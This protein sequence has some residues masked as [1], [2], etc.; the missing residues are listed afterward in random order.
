MS[1]LIILPDFSGADIAFKR[2]PLYTSRVQNTVSGREVAISYESYPRY[3]WQLKF[4]VLRD[5]VTTP[6]AKQLE[7]IFHLLAGRGDYFLFSDPQRGSVVTPVNIGTGTGAAAQFRA[8]FLHTEPVSG[9]T[10]LE[11]VQNIYNFTVYVNGV[12]QTY[13]TA[14]TVSSTGLITFKAGYIPA[15]G[16]AVTWKGGF[17][18]RC[19]L[20]A[21]TFDLD[22]IVKDMWSSSLKFRSV[23]V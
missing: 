20:L 14:Y 18:Y 7:A 8:G 12:A 6:E 23:K 11:P 5:Y 9:L 4:N 22:R 21:D 10:F 19:R 13:V 16:A 1:D 3:Q 2:S 17:R 15:A